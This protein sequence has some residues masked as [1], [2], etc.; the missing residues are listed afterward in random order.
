MYKWWTYCGVPAR[1][2]LHQTTL[3]SGQWQVTWSG[4]LWSFHRWT[5]PTW[6]PPT[7]FNN[8]TTLTII[9]VCSFV[10]VHCLNIFLTYLVYFQLF[11]E[12]RTTHQLQKL[13]TVAQTCPHHLV[14]TSTIMPSIITFHHDNFVNY[15]YMSVTRHLDGLL[16]WF[17][18]NSPLANSEC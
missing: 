7:F 2:G 13:S 11:S 4:I 16:F 18:F 1:W 3:G 17:W 9:F 14:C 10:H 6:E 15:V 5:R 8:G 12:L